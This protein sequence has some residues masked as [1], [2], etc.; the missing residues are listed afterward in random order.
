M[1]S[2]ETTKVG[3]QPGETKHFNV[4]PFLDAAEQLVI[5]DDIARALDVL[6]NLPGRYREHRPKEVVEMR[7]TIM[8]Q[9]MNNADYVTNPYDD[10][11]SIERGQLAIKTT[12]RGT[13]VKNDVEA[14]NKE[15]K[16]PHIID[17]G[18]G[19]YWL[20]LGLK[21]FG[22]KFTYD[23][24]S[25]QPEIERKAKQFIGDYLVEK[26]PK[27]A[28]IL[29]VANEIIEHLWFE[30]EIYQAFVK[31]GGY[32]DYVYVST[33][34]YTFG[35]GNPDWRTSQLGHLRTYT[36]SEFGNIVQKMFKGFKWT[37]MNHPIMI[38]ED[39][40]LSDVMMFKGE[41]INGT[42]TGHSQSQ[43]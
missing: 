16:T 25:L 41:N 37:F 24:I 1:N 8:R 15:G 42:R 18:P 27:D 12:L 33:P 13:V 20:P 29:F 21:G 17:V 40:D 10:F 11:V 35:E 19:E 34:M 28:P 36:P 9:L 30:E 22:L 39:R 26:A 23:A 31:K 32:A 14:L 2:N 7:D 38:N 3:R 43:E 6:D 5:H 4:Q